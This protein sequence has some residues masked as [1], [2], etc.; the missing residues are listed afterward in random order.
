VKKINL[1]VIYN[2][3]VKD[4]KISNLN[5]INDIVTLVKE[6]F[7]INEEK[8]IIISNGGYIYNE[9]EIIKETNLKTNDLLKI[10]VSDNE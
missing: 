1:S 9:A 6:I 2:D 4:L 10:E 7:N 5:S 3:D 8:I